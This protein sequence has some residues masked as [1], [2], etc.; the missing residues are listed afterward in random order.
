[1]IKIRRVFAVHLEQ[2]GGC[3]K[4]PRERTSSRIIRLLCFNLSISSRNSG[5][6]SKYHL[7]SMTEVPLGK[8]RAAELVISSRER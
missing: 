8:V 1:M 7:V 6:G 3:D 2:A 4:P 5:D